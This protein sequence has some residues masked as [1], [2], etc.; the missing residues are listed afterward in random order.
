VSGCGRS[1]RVT[2]NVQ[3]PTRLQTVNNVEVY[4]VTALGCLLLVASPAKSC[5]KQLRPRRVARKIQIGSCTRSTYIRL[6]MPSPL[7]SEGVGTGVVGD[8]RGTTVVGWVDGWQYRSS[9][10]AAK[11]VVHAS[12]CEDCSDGG[13]QLPNPNS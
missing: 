10:S 1:S 11:V 8:G 9:T 7:S 4:T 3:A 2:S 12:R 5:S 13:V 6:F